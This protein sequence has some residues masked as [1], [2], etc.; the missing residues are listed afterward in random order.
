MPR[1]NPK[2]E[3][4]SSRM[5]DLMYGNDKNY[6]IAKYS[7]LDFLYYV[8]QEKEK[9]SSWDYKTSSKRRKNTLANDV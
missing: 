6:K 7:F 3:S 2:N 5:D 4:I 9:E 1:F 8:D